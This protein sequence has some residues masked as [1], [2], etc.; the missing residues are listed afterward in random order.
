MAGR[1]ILANAFSLNML[2]MKGGYAELCVH[3][4]DAE[5]WLEELSYHL[6]TVGVEC[7]IGHKSTA[8]LVER[9]LEMVDQSYDEPPGFGLYCQ[10]KQVQ[11][12]PGDLIYVIQL[13]FRPEEGRIYDYGEIVQLLR[14]DRIGFY[15]VHYGPC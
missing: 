8:R 13:A 15:A 9:M 2:D 14:E 10:R 4:Y 6:R 7:V 5:A 11:L 1:V 3:E 12:E